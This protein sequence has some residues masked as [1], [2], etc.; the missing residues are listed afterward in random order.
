MG[1]EELDHLDLVHLSYQDALQNKVTQILV[2]CME[3]LETKY[4]LFNFNFKKR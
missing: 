3:Y 4:V 1:S 2:D